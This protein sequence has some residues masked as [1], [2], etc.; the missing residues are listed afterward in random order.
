MAI[1]E[2]VGRRTFFLMADLEPKEVA[3][4]GVTPGIPLD[5]DTTLEAIGHLLAYWT[6]TDEQRLEKLQATAQDMF[7]ITLAIYM[8]IRRDRGDDW[9][10]LPQRAIQHSWLETRDVEAR[11]NVVGTIHP[12]YR[13]QLASGYQLEIDGPRAEDFKVSAR[14]AWNF[15]DHSNVRIAFRDFL[16]SAGQR[17][18]D[19]FLY[20]YRAVENIRRA[21]GP[22]KID[23]SDR[24]TADWQSMHQALGT[25]EA[26]LADLTAAATCI[27]HG[28]ALGKGLVNARSNREPVLQLAD[29]VLRRYLRHEGVALGLPGAGEA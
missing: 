13:Q 17:G 2:H 10:S 16:V 12:R 14:A 28:D 1:P 15:I 5:A 20:A 23:A 6:I 25:S 9:G 4:F 18:D 19:S 26:L 29:D 7:D 11:A 24:A 3:N 27:R 22:D 21:L 8:L